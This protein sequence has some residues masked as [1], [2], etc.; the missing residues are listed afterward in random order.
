MVGTSVEAK[1]FAQQLNDGRQR[2][3]DGAHRATADDARRLIRDRE[4]S[5]AYQT[6]GDHA[7]LFVSPAD[8]ATTATAVTEAFAPSR[9]PGT[10]R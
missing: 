1:V 10:G 4:I 5:G 3:A 9:T 7:V 6:V 2:R 8:S